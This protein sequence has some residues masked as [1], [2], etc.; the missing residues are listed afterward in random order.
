MT[1]VAG[2]PQMGPEVLA[3]AIWRQTFGGAEAQVPSSNG[4]NT[5]AC[6]KALI[7]L[8]GPLYYVDFRHF[9]KSSLGQL[10][11]QYYKQMSGRWPITA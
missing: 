3:T 6:T 4:C 9:G 7:I 8:Y 2:T 11:H 10:E 5:G 1:L